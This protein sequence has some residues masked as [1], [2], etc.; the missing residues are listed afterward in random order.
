MTPKPTNKTGNLKKFSPALLRGWQTRHVELKDGILKYY[1]EAGG[2]MQNQ[3]TLNFHL[4]C[5]S[6]TQSPKKKE[7]FSITFSG[8]EREFWFKAE[9]EAQ[10]L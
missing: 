10:A 5:C 6:V 4:Y 3:G 2:R 9:N 8:N 7:Q 1:K